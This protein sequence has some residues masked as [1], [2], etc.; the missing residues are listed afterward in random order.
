M[1][2]YGTHSSDLSSLTRAF[3]ILIFLKILNGECLHFPFLI[4]SLHL[5]SK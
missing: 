5:N 4:V 2:E 1:L 3:E